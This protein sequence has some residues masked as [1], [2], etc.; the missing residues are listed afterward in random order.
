M[1]EVEWTVGPIPIDDGAGK[2]IIIRYDTDIQNQAKFYTD[3][4]GREVLERTRDYRPTWNYSRVETVSG[5]YYPIN[6]RIWIKDQTRQLTVLTGKEVSDFRSNNLFVFFLP[7]RSEGGSSI[8][9]GSIEIMV[10]RRTLCDDAL[11]VGEP[12][13]ETAFDT[14][15]VVRGK[16][17]LILDDPSTS[18]LSHRV[19]SQYLFMHPLA[20]YA[21]PHLSYADYITKYR[22]TWSALID[23]LPLNVHLLTLDQLDTNQYL[24]RVEHYFEMND[25]ETYSQP[26]IVDLQ[27]IFNTQGLISDI[28]EL[29]LGA[30]LALTDLKRLEW[31][32]IDQ[33][34]SKMKT[35]GMF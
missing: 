34:S 29:T 17:F 5:N 10:H 12:L 18:A 20:T 26:V 8:Q 27:K 28:E 30:N 25:D 35:P 15:L 23:D 14:G 21:L 11:G 3:A 22:Q 19:A 33:Q 32:T 4:N 13:N 7:D 24:I 16:H 1:V 2:E 31:T 6:S 9:D